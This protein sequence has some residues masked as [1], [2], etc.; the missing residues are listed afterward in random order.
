[1]KSTLLFIT[2]GHGI[3]ISNEREQERDGERKMK[4]GMR[5]REGLKEGEIDS[6]KE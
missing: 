1:M 6:I 4:R 2:S 3:C 5:G